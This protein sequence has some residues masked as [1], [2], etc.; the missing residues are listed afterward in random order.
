MSWSVDKNTMAV[1]MHKGD[2][3]AYWV[4]LVGSQGEFDDGDVAL[5][6]VKQGNTVYLYRE[7]N[8]NPETPSEIEPGD[9]KIL[10]YFQNSTTDTWS[11]G[12]YQTEIRVARNPQRDTDNKVVDGDNVR[13]VIKSTLTIQDVLI[14]I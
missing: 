7:Y 4:T 12:S 6:E 10:I 11:P 5:Y 13:T 14:N 9:G 3:G 8:L 2:T 1:T